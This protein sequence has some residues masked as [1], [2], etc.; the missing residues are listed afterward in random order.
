[1]SSIISFL[2]QKAST[3]LERK[4]IRDAP[5]ELWSRKSDSAFLKLDILSVVKEPRIGE[6][7]KFK[8]GRGRQQEDKSKFRRKPSEL[9][10]KG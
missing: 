5:E 8:I 7:S 9:C 3:T 1:M 10:V 2:G 4:I 6:F